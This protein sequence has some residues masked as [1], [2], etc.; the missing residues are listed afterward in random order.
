MKLHCALGLGLLW[1]TTHSAFWPTGEKHGKG[2]NPGRRA[3]VGD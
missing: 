2:I 3:V 1:S